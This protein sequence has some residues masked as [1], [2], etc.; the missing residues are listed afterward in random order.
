MQCSSLSDSAEWCNESYHDLNVNETKEM[1]LISGDRG[2]LT[3]RSRYIMKLW[4]ESIHLHLLQKLISFS[5]DPTVLN[6][7]L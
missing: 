3:G 6:V 2:A 1:K 7:T 5:V 4:K